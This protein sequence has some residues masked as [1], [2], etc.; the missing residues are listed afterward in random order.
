MSTLFMVLFLFFSSKDTIYVEHLYQQA[1]SYFVSGVQSYGLEKAEFF[2]L[3][4]PL[5]SITPPSPTAR[6]TLVLSAMVCI[7]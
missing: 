2:L 1:L 3:F 5:I 7:S 6:F 4:F